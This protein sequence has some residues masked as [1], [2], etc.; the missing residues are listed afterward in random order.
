MRLNLSSLILLSSLALASTAH[1]GCPTDIKSLQQQSDALC[2]RVDAWEKHKG[3][4]PDESELD[5]MIACLDPFT[6]NQ[7]NDVLGI[8]LMERSALYGY[9]TKDYKSLFAKKA[10]GRA[11]WNDILKATQ[12]DKS[13]PEIWVT[14]A[15]G[16]IGMRADSGFDKSAIQSSLGINLDQEKEYGLQGLQSV[17]QTPEVVAIEAKL[18]ASE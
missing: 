7:S 8:A 14:F 2:D 11:S 4:K 17:S 5:S 15:T 6:T 13:S 12:L 1:A 10:P 18:R 9:I 3:S 16:V